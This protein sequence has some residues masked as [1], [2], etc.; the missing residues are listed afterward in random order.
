MTTANA[1]FG[2]L[3]ADVEVN[4][5]GPHGHVIDL[6]ETTSHEAREFSSCSS[7]PSAKALSP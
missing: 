1:D 3:Q 7:L 6:R 2:L 5:V 4:A